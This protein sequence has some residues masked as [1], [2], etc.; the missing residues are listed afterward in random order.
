MRLNEVLNIAKSLTKLN[1][2]IKSKT[3]TDM[4][5]E[6]NN[7]NYFYKLDKNTA[8]NRWETSL[9]YFDIIR[10]YQ[11][12]FSNGKLTLDMLDD[13]KKRKE[14]FPEEYIRKDSI[15]SKYNDNKNFIQIVLKQIEIKTGNH[16]GISEIND[17]NLE[18]IFPENAKKKIYKSKLQFWISYD[19]KLKAIVKD[20]TIICYISYDNY[21]TWYTVNPEYKGPSNIDINLFSKSYLDI[22]SN[23]EFKNFINNAFN[24]LEKITVTYLEN[25][26][27][28]NYNLNNVKKLQESGGISFIY[29]VNDEGMK[30][31]DYNE[32]HKSRLEYKKFLDD[33][34]HM[35]LVN[36]N[37]YNNI[38]KIRNSENTSSK[39]INYA[40]KLLNL[41]E[42]IFI[43]LQSECL[44]YITDDKLNID[45]N[46]IPT[47][48]YSYEYAKLKELSPNLIE[49]TEPWKKRASSKIYKIK[50]WSI[51]D[52]FFIICIYIENLINKIYNFYTQLE[53]LDKLKQEENK[54]NNAIIQQLNNIKMLY[55]KL[56]IYKDYHNKPEIKSIINFLQKNN[57]NIKYIFNNL[58]N[59]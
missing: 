34:I 38:I 23:N 27:K 25:E 32:I 7:S 12:L 10:R 24:K 13:P 39:F 29:V 14:I 45:C 57:I 37:R 17:N 16:I 5:T 56:I 43:T 40:D 35:K 49:D 1:E 8:K 44:N 33:Y 50:L 4:F 30:N 41:C 59:L 21:D 22:S 11:D 46:Y 51:G 3:L 53:T 52:C 31:I 55:E 48:P 9:D 20:N 15:K 18:K 2:S 28:N 54:N 19:N 58:I 47:F 26:L 42:D 6:I 36:I